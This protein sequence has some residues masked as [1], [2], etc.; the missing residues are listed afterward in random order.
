M[1]GL[2]EELWTSIIQ[3]LQ[4][5]DFEDP[6]Y[7]GRNAMLS[8]EWIQDVQNLR[9][10]SRG[11]CRFVSPI[12]ARMVGEVAYSMT[13]RSLKSLHGLSQNQ[14]VASQVT[15]LTFSTAL[16]VSIPDPNS[17]FSHQALQAAKNVDQVDRQCSAE[18]ED[19]MYWLEDYT[20]C[21]EEQ[22]RFRKCDRLP[23]LI[24]ILRQFTFL[25]TLRILTIHRATKYMKWPYAEIALM[26]GAALSIQ[27]TKENWPMLREL[28]VPKYTGSLMKQVRRPDTLPLEEIWLHVMTAAVASGSQV[29]DIQVISLD[30]QSQ[31]W[32]RPFQRLEPQCPALNCLENLHT[33]HFEYNSG[34]YLPETLFVLYIRAPA[35]RQLS[36]VG[37]G[38]CSNRDWQS[39][40]N[41]SKATSSQRQLKR[42]NPPRLKVLQI[43]DAEIQSEV[44]Q[45]F[46][47]PDL[48]QLALWWLDHDRGDKLYMADKPFF[49]A[50]PTLA[51]NLKLLSV[52]KVVSNYVEPIELDALRAYIKTIAY[53]YIPVC[54]PEAD[55][56]W[57]LEAEA[58]DVQL[59]TH[60]STR[61]PLNEMGEDMEP[62]SMYIQVHRQINWVLELNKVPCSFVPTF[63]QTE[64]QLK[65]R[66]KALLLEEGSDSGEATLL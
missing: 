41:P 62:A 51:P 20:K 48:E 47:T 19:I 32:Y 1:F 27:Q 8:R 2:P 36:V 17:S 60:E 39:F 15:T 59:L 4:E 26:D 24:E 63:R 12:F 52:I 38:R 66:L 33:F 31:Q 34:I 9:L 49:E 11:L 37:S 18:D 45:Y 64:V 14:A 46:L 44:L 7:Q 65:E 10:T 28:S 53:V 42:L 40:T 6:I 57:G 5:E 56:V 43:V 29:N 22:E 3:Y 35:L 61:Y 50:L 25:H 30:D 55:P 23:M 16:L 13:P 21:Y 58:P 54:D